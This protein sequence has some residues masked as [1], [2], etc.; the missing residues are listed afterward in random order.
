MELRDYQQRAVDMVYDWM[1]RHKGNPCIVAPTG[2]GKSI[3]I[4]EICRSL[5]QRYPRVRILML[6]HVRELIEQNA[7]KLKQHWLDAPVGIYSAGLG[8][9]ELSARIIFAGIQSIHSMSEHMGRFD[10]ILVDECHLIS[11]RQTGRYREL[12]DAV[13]ARNPKA[14]VIGLTAT[15]YRLGHG[16]ITDGDGIFDALLEPTSIMQLV[17]DGYLAPL[18]SKLTREQYELDAVRQRGGEYVESALQAAVDTDEHNDAV[19]DEIVSKA[20]GRRHWMA[21]CTGVEHAYHIRD[22]LRERGVSADTIVGSTKKD[23]RDGIIEAFKHG[24][25]QCITNANVLTTGFDCPD[26]DL[27]AMLRPTQSRSLY[28]QMAGR[29]MRPKSHTD[30]CMVLDFAGNV[31]R[32]GPV[33]ELGVRSRGKRSSDSSAPTKACPACYEI[34]MAGASACHMCGHI[35]EQQNKTEL[36]LSY[37]DDIMG[38]DASEAGVVTWRWTVHVGMRSGQ[39]MLMCSYITDRLKTSVKEY[40]TVLNDGWAG[41]K[42]RKNLHDI[43]ARAGVELPSS[44]DLVNIAHAMQSGTPPLAIQYRLDGRHRN[45]VGHRWPEKE[46]QNDRSN[47][48]IQA[49]I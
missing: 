22:A 45:V 25:I 46:Y 4:A 17:T 7:D 34:V 1:S 26:V 40:F 19:V 44:V 41:K 18:R 47:Q 21:F 9:R 11:H 14:R 8:R 35:F 49:E 48:A 30:H 13:Q 20:G 37:D 16:L 12:I 43:A 42:A 24:K 29:G 2:S 6:T 31:S 5:V 15:P 27:I 23:Q 36:A 3:I 28:V 38:V 39:Q 10:L 32:H 33:T